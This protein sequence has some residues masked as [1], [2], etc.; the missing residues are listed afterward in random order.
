MGHLPLSKSAVTIWRLL[1]WSLLFTA[2]L[3]SMLALHFY[4]PLPRLVRNAF[5]AACACWWIY[6]MR[7]TWPEKRRLVAFITTLAA[8]VIAWSF[9][10]PTVDGDWSRLHSTMVEAEFGD[11]VVMLRNVRDTDQHADGTYEVGFLDREIDLRRVK[12]VWFG[13]QQF[14][15]WRGG[16]HTFVSFGLEGDDYL[17]IS[18]EARRGEGKPFHPLRGMF[19]QCGLIYVVGSEFDIIGNR[20]ADAEYPVYLYPIQATPAQAQQM[21][22]AMLKRADGLRQNPEFYHTTLNNCTTNIVQSF[23]SIAPIRISPHSPSVKFPGYSGQ[24]AYDQGLINNDLP[25]EQ[26]QQM[27]RINERARGATVEDF[28]QCIRS[29]FVPEDGD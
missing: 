22:V 19:R 29:G 11:D 15:S 3:W 8:I 13:V 20:V 24:V 28:S 2:A 17:A 27:A 23:N 25:F 14:I 18:V 10:R 7:S 9:V 5:A 1:Y 16:S 6:L 21:L 26:I 4:T 12:S